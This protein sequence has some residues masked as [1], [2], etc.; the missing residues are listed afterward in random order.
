MFLY[1]ILF[2]LIFGA[3]LVGLG[4]GLRRLTIPFSSVLLLP[5]GYAVCVLVSTFIT[6][7][8]VTAP[9]S[10]PV[11]VILAIAGWVVGIRGTYTVARL[12][13]GAQREWPWLA[14]GFGGM[15]AFG[16]SAITN[17]KPTFTGYNEIV[18]IGYQFDWANYLGEHGRQWVDKSQDSVLNVVSRTLE[19][20][21]PSGPQAVL[22]TIPRL[23]GMHLEWAYQP[24][25]A[26]IAGCLVLAAYSLIR[27]VT[28]SRKFAALGAFAA[29][30]SSVLIA[31]AQ[32]GGI[33]E[34][35]G[36][37]T[38]MTAAAF[39]NSARGHTD[40]AD[41]RVALPVAVGFGAA[42]TVFSITLLPWLALLGLGALLMVWR[43]IS[44]PAA[45]RR[46]G[47]AL[48]GAALLSLPTIFAALDSLGYASV[49]E[50]QTEVGNLGAPIDR[51]AATGI[52]LAADHR[53]ALTGDY[54]TASIIVGSIVIVLALLG[55]VV[56]L[57]KRQPAMVILA[58]ASLVGMAFLLQRMGPWVE[59]KGV[60]LMGP[61]MLVLAAAGLSALVGNRYLDKVAWYG[62]ALLL[63]TGVAGDIL[64]YGNAQMAPYDRLSELGKIGDKYAG[65]K[66]V[67]YPDADEHGEYQL[68]KM[69]PAGPYNVSFPPT[70]EWAADP[71]KPAFQLIWDL[72]QV[73]LGFINTFD[74]VVTRHAP[75]Q[76]RPPG[77]FELVSE[78][79]QYDVW[80][81]GP[82]PLPTSHLALTGNDDPTE[83]QKC[84]AFV[85]AVPAGGTV[86]IAPAAPTSIA[87][88]D[89]AKLGGGM[90]SA[91]EGTGVF[92]GPKTS[93]AQGL[94]DVGQTP[95][96]V[97]V[98][99]ANTSNRKVTVTLGASPLV[100]KRD[101][102]LAF[103]PSY[104]GTINLDSGLQNVTLDGGTTEL[105]SGTNTEHNKFA[106]VGTITI[107]P[108]GQLHPKTLTTL[109]SDTTCPART[110][111]VET[112]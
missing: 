14:A 85:D 40:R 109:A 91:A 2:P 16:A 69:H 55:A 104:L 43:G 35:A 50:Q 72:D 64:R 46:G 44:L 42:F 15:V 4:L 94:I 102:T 65:V 83:Q 84:Q 22:G 62:V 100:A 77:Q 111:W 105:R 67:L 41:W 63:F 24:M 17:G 47:F 11:V 66:N 79:R 60:T 89:P 32:I 96:R 107:V 28:D 37:A 57:R 112:P 78:G 45:A 6:W 90:T 74:Y 98:Y 13:E 51:W 31:Y 12:R 53:Y 108:E 21:Y 29:G 88:F 25:M 23:F 20:G 82:R 8:H 30:Q 103:R 18:D 26:I 56:A 101:R 95:A 7:W 70:A 19:V 49:M 36:A 99:L 110:D 9:I 92:M 71:T 86:T 73:D 61:P 81:K 27:E 58:F 59:F 93:Q 5:A 80:K 87:R 48:V 38:L 106:Y 97:E 76:S 54:R 10:A 34:L 39:L 1:W 52:W 68:R 33:K 75:G 3:I